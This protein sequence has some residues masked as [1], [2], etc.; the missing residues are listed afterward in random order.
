MWH[1]V[2]SRMKKRRLEEEEGFANSETLTA[3][4]NGTFVVQLKIARIGARG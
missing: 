1:S 3:L 2:A 4:T